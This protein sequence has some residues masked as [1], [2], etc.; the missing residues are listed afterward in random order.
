MMQEV[1]GWTA[2]GMAAV[3]NMAVWLKIIYDRKKENGKGNNK[4][5]HYP[6]IMENKTRSLMNKQAIDAVCKNI[7]NMKE[8]NQREHDVISQ[9]LDKLF[10][11]VK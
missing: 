10:E 7:N 3:A 2:V 4:N 5:N 11:K 8:D 9:K 1:T 6:I